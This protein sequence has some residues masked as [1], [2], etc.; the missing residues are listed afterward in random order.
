[1]SKNSCKP[2]INSNELWAL[3]TYFALHYSRGLYVPVSLLKRL[4]A[5]E[6]VEGFDTAFVCLA[7][8]SC[9]ATYSFWVSW[10]AAVQ[11]NRNKHKQPPE[12]TGCF[13]EHKAKMHTEPHSYLWGFINN[14]CSAMKNGMTVVEV[15][16][17]CISPAAGGWVR[18]DSWGTSASYVQLATGL[19]YLSIVLARRLFFVAPIPNVTVGEQMGS[20]TGS[21]K[22]RL[23]KQGKCC[24]PHGGYSAAKIFLAM[25]D[26][27]LDGIYMAN[28]IAL[29]FGLLAFDMYTMQ[30]VYLPIIGIIS[31]WSVLSRSLESFKDAYP[32]DHCNSYFVPVIASWYFIRSL[33]NS[34]K[35]T[36]QVC[37][38]AQGLVRYEDYPTFD[39][40]RIIDDLALT[41]KAAAFLVIGTAIGL[42]DA[43]KR[44]QKYLQSNPS[45]C[46][47]GAQSDQKDVALMDVAQSNKNSA[48]IWICCDN[49][50][51]NTTAYS[52]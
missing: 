46:H 13:A 32:E 38:F 41:P 6:L 19:S 4:L 51:S 40:A 3:G 49:G 48:N 24:T 35:N 7:F 47:K 10:E 11:K 27:I 14:I 17:K 52:V 39:L 20:G 21:P 28:N 15:V 1:M 34:T 31:V 26:A 45:K 36:L 2:Q 30:G 18:K 22:H 33:L 37:V 5:L 43:Y 9:F 12:P 16:A 50:S 8:S 29:A 44:G 25:L 23:A 42:L